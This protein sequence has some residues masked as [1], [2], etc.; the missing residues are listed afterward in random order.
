MGCY[1][2]KVALVLLVPLCLFSILGRQTNSH[3]YNNLSGTQNNE[4]N[5][6]N[7]GNDNLKNDGKYGN[8]WP[9]EYYMP[10]SYLP[11]TQQTYDQY[12]VLTDNIIRLSAIVDK[13]CDLHDSV[14]S[15]FQ[16]AAWAISNQPSGAQNKNEDTKPVYNS[17]SLNWLIV[18]SIISSWTL[19]IL[20]ISSIRLN[21]QFMLIGTSVVFYKAPFVSFMGDLVG[22]VYEWLVSSSG[23][24]S[25]SDS[26]DSEEFKADD[27]MGRCPLDSLRTFDHEHEDAYDCDKSPSPSLNDD[28]YPSLT[29]SPS[30]PLPL[31]ETS[32]GIQEPVESIESIEVIEIVEY[33]R[34]W[35]ALGW[36]NHMMPSENGPF[37]NTGTGVSYTSLRDAMS[38]IT[39]TTHTSISNTSITDTYA[40]GN[41]HK[42]VNMMRLIVNQKTDNEGWQY[43]TTLSNN[44]TDNNNSSNR[45]SMHTYIRRR[46]YITPSTT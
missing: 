40:D 4:K 15:K 25:K 10:L 34:Y 36:L 7:Y 2:A 5:N 16:R 31:K 35:L 28:S 38:A 41:G 18:S 44:T 42:N 33:Q 17:N 1:H 6:L 39:N 19:F 11:T 3:S 9:F 46:T 37:L 30:S 22:D 20:L 12:T 45:S 29:H 27:Q 23:R 8:G 32:R 43:F 24:G 14:V 26:E 21:Y 13:I